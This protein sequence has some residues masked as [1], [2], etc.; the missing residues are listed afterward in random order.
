MGDGGQIHSFCFFVRLKIVHKRK[1]KTRR[2][3]PS[4][5]CLAMPRNHLLPL[6]SDYPAGSRRAWETPQM[7]FC[8]FLKSLVIFTTSFLRLNLPK[9]SCPGSN[10]N[11]GWIETQNRSLRACQFDN[12]RSCLQFPPSPRS[13][14]RSVRLL[15]RS[16]SAHIVPP[17]LPSRRALPPSCLTTL[18]LE[19]STGRVTGGNGAEHPA[20]CRASRRHGVESW[21]KTIQ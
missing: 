5:F 6:F 20:R 1:V 11:H 2:V 7:E 14:P 15:P 4:L 16:C 13:S 12:L 10:R 17:V 19:S 3:M 9:S 18:G 21:R 8:R